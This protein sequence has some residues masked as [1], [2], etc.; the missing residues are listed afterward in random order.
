MNDAA[1]KPLVFP[2]EKLTGTAPG[3]Y[4]DL[5]GDAYHEGPGVSS[6]QLKRVLKSPLHLIYPMIYPDRMDETKKSP[7]LTFGSAAHKY[8]L[9][10]DTFDDEYVLEPTGINKRTKEGKQEYADFVV[11]NEGKEFISAENL[12]TIQW[13]AETAAAS[14]SWTNALANTRREVSIFWEDAESGLLCKCRPDAMKP[15]TL[16]GRRVMICA[17]VKTT[18]DASYTQFSRSI[19]NF[20]YDLSAAM[21]A[22]GIR[23][24]YPDIEDVR[25]LFLAIEKTPPF[26]CAVYSLD[27]HAL[28]IGYRKYRYALTLFKQCLDTGE[29]PSYPDFISPITLPRWALNP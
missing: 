14:T 1:H 6:T 2:P 15:V 26:A 19:A 8:L 27:P 24:T 4:D 28:T 11:A 13:M 22:D 21:Y 5:S 12:Q 23:A 17:D 7:A 3:V 25:F 29:W 20:G 9:E 10:R 18:I 16:N